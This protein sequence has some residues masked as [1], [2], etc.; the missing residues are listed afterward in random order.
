MQQ[1]RWH[2]RCPRLPGARPN[3]PPGCADPRDQKV[4]Y[5]INKAVKKRDFCMPFA[6]AVLR[7]LLGESEAA[8]ARFVADEIVA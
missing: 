1:H 2:I 8:I 6:P 7:E 5:R 3:L 4:V